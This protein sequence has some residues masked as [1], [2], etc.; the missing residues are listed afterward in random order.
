MSRLLS[1]CVPGILDPEQ[2]H[3]LLRRPSSKFSFASFDPGVASSD[4]NLGIR[5]L[6]LNEELYRP[7]RVVV[8]TTC[9]GES[10]WRFVPRARLGDGVVDEGTWP[11][12]VDICGQQFQMSQEQWDIYKLDPAYSCTVRPSPELTCITLAQVPPSESQPL[13]KHRMSS[14]EPCMPPSKAARVDDDSDDDSDDAFSEM[15]VDDD[16]R[17]PPR[18]SASTAKRQRDELEKKRKE[19][20]EKGARR[21]EQLNGRHDIPFLFVPPE[22]SPE[23]TKRKASTLFDSLRTHDDPDYHTRAHEQHQDRNA[24]NYSPTKN[25]KRTRTFSPGA[26]K[27]DL[28]SRRSE[29]EKQKRERREQEWHRRKERKY[30]QFL[31]ELYA[32]SLP[33]GPPPPPQP[34]YDEDDNMSSDSEPE[35]DD[36]PAGPAPKEDAA[37][38][39]DEEAERLA[40][41]AESRRKLAELEADRPLW[42]QEARKRERR[43]REEEEA[44]RVKAAQRR[45][46]EARIAEEERRARLEKERQAAEEE[47]RRRAAQERSARQKREQ[48]RYE[49]P[50]EGDWN[51]RRALERYIMV[52]DSFDNSK[53]S[54]ADPLVFQA[55][56][57]PVVTLPGT[58]GPEDITWKRVEYF[59]REARTLLRVQ[60]YVKLVQTSHRRFHPDRWRA[61][62][63]LKT[64]SNEAERECLEV[65]VNTVAQALT[66][67]WQ[68]AARR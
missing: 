11:R 38:V 1:G 43:E 34:Q 63:L 59:F 47:E 66:P 29:R 49:K 2:A 18:R 40:A 13:G 46:A 4:Q 26:A 3:R 21:V 53:F 8:E 30:Q 7:K 37:P 10:F 14:A 6:S 33:N 42:E 68:D 16:T 22:P 58:F 20:R 61:R 24:V 12:V 51:S 25:A 35:D 32:S 50:I 39:S 54:M 23:K 52:A 56:P 31:D 19:R 5:N 65:A 57:W 36:E 64:V 67:L 28:E 15:A 9:T 44:V 62:N 55:I 17:I 27:R 48:R 60:D 45:A 41:I